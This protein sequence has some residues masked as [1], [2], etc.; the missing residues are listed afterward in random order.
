MT[1]RGRLSARSHISFDLSTTGIFIWESSRRPNWAWRSRSVVHGT[2]DDTQGF[3]DELVLFD[4]RRALATAT[5]M[6][7]GAEHDLLE[8]RIFKE[9]HD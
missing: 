4:N 7:L 9:S 2:S 6:V 5:K 8:I 3:G 1:Q